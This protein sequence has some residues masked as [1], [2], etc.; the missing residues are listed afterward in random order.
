MKTDE[1]GAAHETA[2]KNCGIKM[3]AIPNVMPLTKEVSLVLI[4][5]I[6]IIILVSV[7]FCYA[8][9]IENI[10]LHKSIFCYRFIMIN[11]YFS[12]ILYSLLLFFIAQLAKRVINDRITGLN[13]K[14]HDI[15]GEYFTFK[16]LGG[17]LIV[18]MMLP[19]VGT[20]FDSLKGCIP[21]LRPFDWDVTF[22]KLDYLLHFNHHPWRLLYPVMS[23]TVILRSIDLLYIS[24][25]FILNFLTVWLAWSGRREL[26]MQF[27]I[28]NLLI[29]F[30]IGNV[31]ATIFSSAGP[32]YYDKVIGIGQ[33]P[34]ESLMNRLTTI[35]SGNSQL[36]ALDLQDNLW[37]NR[38]NNYISA[39]PSIHVALAAL[40]ALTM[41]RI[42]FRLG[43][44]FWI[45]WAIIQIGAIM[46]AW[47][48]AIDGYFSTLITLG[49]WKFSGF[50]SHYF[51][52]KLP[53][54]IRLKIISQ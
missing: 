17:V 47:H 10:I 9:L 34:Y 5:H 6:P 51:W 14:L 16:R 41:S 45:Y 49:L 37:I 28:C 2:E 7:Y 12:I 33:N 32:C 50:I 44:V 11:N 18:V 39:M 43:L 1:P 40:F 20:I 23:S 25:F 42:N 3:A 30:I 22:M 29:F 48:Y 36:I 24:W 38:A 26:R 19:L 52:R 46:L 31:L 21:I 35:G 4:E 53:A 27:F 8:F 54:N 13:N 15:A